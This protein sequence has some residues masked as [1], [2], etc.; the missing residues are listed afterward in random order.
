[1]SGRGRALPDG[2]RM[3]SHLGEPA[4]EQQ[5]DSSWSYP[6]RRSPVPYRRPSRRCRA[7]PISGDL[8]RTSC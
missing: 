1:M 8:Q 2:A 5:S 3:V 6:V 4:A 7:T